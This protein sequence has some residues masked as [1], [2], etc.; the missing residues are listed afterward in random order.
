MLTYW[1]TD[2]RKIPDL[3]DFPIYRGIPTCN[4]DINPFYDL[5]SDHSSILINIRNLA[6][7][8][9]LTCHIISFK[10]F[11][12]NNI[13]LKATTNNLYEIEAFVNFMSFMKRIL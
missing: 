12:D 6:E 4:L 13:N 8:K 5:N 9:I 10:G 11:S 2:S 1:L 7:Y 3:I